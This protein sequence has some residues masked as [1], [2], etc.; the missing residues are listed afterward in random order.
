MATMSEGADVHTLIVMFTVDPT[1][2]DTLVE[3]LR[4]MAAEHCKFDGF[5]SC[6]IHRSE[7]VSLGGDRIVEHRRVQRA[8]PPPPPTAPPSHPRHGLPGPT[9]SKTRHPHRHPRPRPHRP[10]R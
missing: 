1:Q 4:G 7:D 5:V 3:H 2:Q 9:Q 10:R 8:P 6:S